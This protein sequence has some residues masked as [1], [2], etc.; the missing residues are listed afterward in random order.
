[1]NN[2]DLI[3]YYGF[4]WFNFIRLRASVAIAGSN[5]HSSS[6]SGLIH[7]MR[8]AKTTEDNKNKKRQIHYQIHCKHCEGRVDSVPDKWC[9]LLIIL[10]I[11][12]YRTE[13]LTRA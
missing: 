6:Y 3:E 2:Y 9:K 5:S 8:A 4:N 1:M 12:T 11:R 10:K 7:L 13:Y